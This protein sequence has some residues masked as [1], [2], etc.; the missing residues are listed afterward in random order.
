[1]EREKPELLEAYRR[2][3]FK[4]KDD[5]RVT[6]VGRVIRRFSVDEL[7]QFFNVL[8]GEM[9][10]VGPRAYKPDELEHQRKQYP[11]CE[12]DI[13]AL[14]TVKPGI[15]GLWQVSGRS[16]L[17]FPQRVALDAV[18]ARRKSLLG[19]LIIALKTPWVMIKGIG[20]Y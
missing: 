7:P 17:A 4:F 16:K 18:Y 8:R 5:P 1:M 13:A 10:L 9:S 2:N 14:F 20:A 11:E 6:K 12:K 19:D 3:N 15:T